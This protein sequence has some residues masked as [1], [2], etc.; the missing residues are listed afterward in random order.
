VN[1]CPRC[2]AA[3][4][5]IE[6]EHVE[7]QDAMYTLDYG[8]LQ[9]ATVR[10]ETIFG[11]VAVAV[12]P[13]DARFTKL[14]GSEATIPLVKRSVPIITDDYVDLKTGT[15]ALKIT[16]GHDPNDYEIGQRHELP[17]LSVIDAAGNMINVPKKYLG[18]PA[19][20]AREEVVKALTK[21]KKL[22]ATEELTHSVAIHDR[23]GTVIE[24]L[25]SK[26]WFL[27]VKELNKPVIKAFEKEEVQIFPK[28]FKKVALDWLSQEHDWCISRDS[29]WWGIRIPA[30]YRDSDDE[31]KD[32]YI[33]AIDEQI[34]IDYYGKGNYRV[35]TATFDTWFS[36]GQWP[37]AT[38]M[39]TGKDDFKDFYPTS[40]MGTAR[41]IVHKWVTRMVMFGLYRTDEVPFRQVYLWGLVT[42]EHGKK[43]SKSK[44]NVVDPLK[45]TATYGTDAL[46]MAGAITNTAGTDSPMSEKQVE[47]MRNFCN[48]LWNVARFVS[49]KI[50]GD[51]QPSEPQVISTADAWMVERLAVVTQT[52]SAKLD[53]YRLNEAAGSVYHLLWDDFADWYLET[54]KVEVNPDM[55]VYG[56]ETILRLAHPFIP[57]VTEAIW[58]SLPHRSTLLMGES[59]PVLLP[60]KAGQGSVFEQLRSIVTEIRTLRSE[61]RLTSN[62]LYHRG[63]ELLASHGELITKLT[64][65]SGVREVADGYGLHLISTPDIAWLDVE[66]EV[67]RGYLFKL[68]QERDRKQE[69][70]LALEARLDNKGYTRHA[71]KELV[72]ETKDLVGETKVIIAK[73]NQQIEALEHSLE[74][75]G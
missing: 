67:T 66:E 2:Q 44:G 73:Y 21:A 29:C 55:L 52:V 57:F 42:D 40:L 28:R 63:S 11:D 25:I 43:M 8:S 30:Y 15:G 60:V 38:L 6:L 33:L 36:S 34:A 5:D 48:K 20:K 14:V 22:L 49:E 72:R 3:F 53:G 12:N 74:L 31:E 59:W 51:Y 70:R 27:R 39:T 58:Q 24:P 68:V 64:G 10:P 32:D 4:A 13:K 56:L 19:D 1:W 35:E 45:V 75:Y 54:S 61:L 17:E 69:Y 71:P 18:L 9:V 16:P 26:Q 65:V 7:R 37:Y 41:E 62:W 50:G 46:R 47:A 23:C